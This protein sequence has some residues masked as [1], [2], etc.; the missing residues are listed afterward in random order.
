MTRHYPDLSTF[1]LESCKKTIQ[2]S[3]FSVMVFVHL[4]Q[5]KC[6][7]EAE[8][9]NHKISALDQIQAITVPL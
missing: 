9:L 1:L 3:I 8:I 7:L 4:N 5:G 6:H 2:F